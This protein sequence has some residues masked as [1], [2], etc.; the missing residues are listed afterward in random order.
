MNILLY[1][2]HH[3]CDN[4]SIYVTQFLDASPYVLFRHTEECRFHV[5]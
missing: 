4:P 3:V 2:F 5:V 1:N